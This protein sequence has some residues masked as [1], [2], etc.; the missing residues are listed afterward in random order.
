M[1]KRLIHSILVLFVVLTAVFLA[2]RILGDPVRIVAGVEVSEE[3]LQ[4]IRERLGLDDPLHIQYVKFLSRAVRL[5]F[6]QSFWQNTPT[7][8]L[9]LKQLPATIQLTATALLLCVPLGIL[10]GISAA[11]KPHK[12]L[13]RVINVLS[14]GGVSMVDFWLALMLILIFA[15]HLGWY[16]TSGYGGFEYIMLPAIALAYAPLGR[17]TQLTRS[18]LLNEFSNPYITVARSKGLSEIRVTFVHALKNAAIPIIT[19]I[20]DT[21]ASMLNGA[22]LIETVFAWPGI[23]LL[24]LQS[25]ERRDLPMVE[26]IV[27]VIAVMVILVNLLVDLSYS[28]LNPAIRYE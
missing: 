6:G 19:I 15:V 26:T 1:L 20:G 12:F 7:L 25:L 2:G 24:T 23:G 21:A 5:D 22:I 10:L 8:P 17:I 9:V 27:F 4:N 18:A 3:H 16:K 28:I 11:L 13:D 14:L